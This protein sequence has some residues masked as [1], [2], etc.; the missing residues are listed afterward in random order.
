[1]IF[2]LQHVSVVNA[3][4]LSA[5]TTWESRPQPAE[6]PMRCAGPVRRSTGSSPRRLWKSSRPAQT[7]SFQLFR[8]SLGARPSAPAPPV[9]SCCSMTTSTA[10]R[11]CVPAALW[12]SALCVWSAQRTVWKQVAHINHALVES[13]HDRRLYLCGSTNEQWPHLWVVI[14]EF[15]NVRFIEAFIWKV[16]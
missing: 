14:V 6:T 16:D 12:A 5:C 7:S 4:P 9:A 15:W 11:L 10:K 1:M 3:D 13:P 2:P 8:G